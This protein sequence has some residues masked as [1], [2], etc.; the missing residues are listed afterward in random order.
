MKLVSMV[1]VAIV[2]LVSFVLVCASAGSLTVTK[3]PNV[4]VVAPHAMRKRDH[5]DDSC[6][7]DT[8]PPVNTGIIV[9]ITDTMKSLKNK[10]YEHKMGQG[11]TL[12]EHN[13]VA[14]ASL[15]SCSPSNGNVLIE[16]LLRPMAGTA[17]PC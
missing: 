16:M 8:G 5:S 4:L 7:I 14:L 15:K 12:P 10:F 2:L 1:L 17:P 13:L 11:P 9:I 6:C 3:D